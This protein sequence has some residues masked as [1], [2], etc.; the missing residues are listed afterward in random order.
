MLAAIIAGCGLGW[1]ADQLF[2]SLPW[3][4]LIGLAFGIAAGMRQLIVFAKMQSK[5][6]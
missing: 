5:G 6:D 4:L 2:H 1:G 3:G